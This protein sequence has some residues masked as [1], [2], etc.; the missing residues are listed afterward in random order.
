MG[1]TYPNSFDSRPKRRKATD[2]PYELFTTGI[3]TA[4]PHY[5]LAFTDSCGSRQFIEIN[6][7]LFNAFDRFE[8]DD[9]SY[10]NKID[11]HYERSEQTEISLNK[12]AVL[13][14][15]ALEEIVFQRVEAEMLYGAID[16]LSNIQRR[17]L[18]LYYFGNLTYAQIAKMEGCSIETVRKSVKAAEHNLKKWLDK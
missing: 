2:N 14:Q 9:I 3:G 11:R 4:Q 12:R 1:R 17:R 6:E 7:T 16:K 8:L 15:V 18:S 10:M 13:P 5:Y